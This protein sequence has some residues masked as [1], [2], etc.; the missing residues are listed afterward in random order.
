MP[1]N[2]RKATETEVPI[3]PSMLLK[4]S[5]L[6]LM[7]EAVAA[8]AMEVITTMQFVGGGKEESNHKFVTCFL[9]PLRV[10]TETKSRLL[11]QEMVLNPFL[12]CNET[13]PAECLI[14]RRLYNANMIQEH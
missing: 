11:S 2:M 9:R 3:M 6:E 12:A 14:H 13:A 5:H 4:A 7:G 1:R 10:T 8:T